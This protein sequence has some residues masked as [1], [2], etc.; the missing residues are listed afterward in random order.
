M[1]KFAANLK[2][3]RTLKEFS[4]D[5]LAKKAGVH[6]THLSR[7]ERGLSTPSLEVAFKI[8]KTLE[9]S[10]DEL[11]HSEQTEKMEQ[12]IKDRELL[13]MFKKAQV[14]SDKQKECIKEFMSAFLLKAD[15]QKNLSAL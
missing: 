6:V 5:E 14:L 12:T 15:V 1:T 9:I 10:I 8:A 13:A 11:A 3:Y 7:Y 4:Q 2:K